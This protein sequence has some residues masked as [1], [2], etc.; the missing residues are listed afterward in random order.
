MGQADPEPD[1]GQSAE[2]GKGE[3]LPEGC[4]GRPELN[5]I[6]HSIRFPLPPGFRP[7]APQGHCGRQ[8]ADRS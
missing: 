1:H 7:I 3:S 4:Y 8:Q 5:F 6:S 2:Y